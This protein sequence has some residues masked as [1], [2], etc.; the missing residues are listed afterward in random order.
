M[1]LCSDYKT[2]VI[3][4]SSLPRLC[5]EARDPRKK[6]G[7]ISGP[8]QRYTITI[9]SL[10]SLRDAHKGFHDRRAVFNITKSERSRK[11]PM[12]GPLFFPIS[13]ATGSAR[14]EVPTGLPVFQ[15]FNN[16]RR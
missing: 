12:A 2:R 9:E 4:H 1:N 15:K 10:S 16:E 7:T 11:I 8:L 14:N 5:R 13:T 6:I 3:R